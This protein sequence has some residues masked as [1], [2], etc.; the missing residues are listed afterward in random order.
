MYSTLSSSKRFL[1][2]LSV[3]VLLTLITYGL[4]QAQQAT[5]TPEAEPTGMSAEADT[6]VYVRF[7]DIEW[8]PCEGLPGCEFFVLR[9]DQQTGP[10]ETL[11]RLQPS[12]QIAA[13]WHTSPEH[14]IGLAGTMVDIG[15]NG[16]ARTFGPG[17]FIYAP[18]EAVHSLVCAG[19]ETCV[20][21]AY[22]ELPLDFPFVTE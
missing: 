2:V 6:L 9:G 17:D 18:S 7:N 14:L 21:Y 5:P 13:H 3:L 22:E 4:S 11:W 20:L 15:G 12:L 10:S 19:D 1:V 16:Q 8:Q